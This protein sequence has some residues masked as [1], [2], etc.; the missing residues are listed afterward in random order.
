MMKTNPQID[1]D[2]LFADSCP[3]PDNFYRCK[4]RQSRKPTQAG[5]L[6]NAKYQIEMNKP[7]Y[8][9]QF[10]PLLSEAEAVSSYS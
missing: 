2:K 6:Q 1:A 10:S 5:Y 7:F 9:V 3:D 4:Y 8:H